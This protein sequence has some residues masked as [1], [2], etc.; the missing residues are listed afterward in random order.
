MQKAR[1]RK[2]RLVSTGRTT[3]TLMSHGMAATLWSSG[4]YVLVCARSLIRPGYLS[5]CAFTGGEHLQGQGAGESLS[6][7]QVRHNLI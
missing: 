7:R 4:A 5:V 1:G 3:R 6:S 2:W